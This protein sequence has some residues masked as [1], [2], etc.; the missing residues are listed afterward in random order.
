[1]KVDERTLVAQD[2]C[3]FLEFLN[4]RRRAGQAM[5]EGEITLDFKSAQRK[6]GRFRMPR[7]QAWALKFVQCAQALEIDR[8]DFFSS[9]RGV[10]IVF[11]TDELPPL[12]SMIEGLETFANCSEPEEHLRAALLALTAQPGEVQVCYQGASWDGREVSVGEGNSETF[13]CTLAYQRARAFWKWLKFR[14]TASSGLHTELT[15]FAYLA[16][17]NVYLDQRP[18]GLE[19]SKMVL[20]NGVLND[21]SGLVLQVGGDI[22]CGEAWPQ[23]VFTPWARNQSPTYSYVV[24]ADYLGP[25]QREDISLEW[26]RDGV[27]VERETRELDSKMGVQVRVLLSADGLPA[28]LSGFALRDNEDRLWRRRRAT[29]YAWHGLKALQRQ[30]RYPRQWEIFLRKLEPE[31]TVPKREE[32]LAEVERLKGLLQPPLPDKATKR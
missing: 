30:L 2:R 16:P 22:M 31:Q 3:E 24:R 8:I 28:D 5:G 27:V 20:L 26:V 25:G 13:R 19:S 10:E 18:V 23:P 7:E 29:F 15:Q 12:E 6:L 4:S 9:R 11:R 17:V 21:R 14:I 1:M 32:L